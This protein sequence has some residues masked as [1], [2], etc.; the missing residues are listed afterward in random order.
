[1]LL[2]SLIH[3]LGG[4]SSSINR[5]SCYT[6]AELS[7]ISVNSKPY[8]K[9]LRAGLPVNSFFVPNLLPN[10]IAQRDEEMQNNW[11]PFPLLKYFHL[12]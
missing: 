3:P 5:K 2:N 4:D 9:T 11:M 12:Q 1:M 6:S 10:K 8:S 7:N